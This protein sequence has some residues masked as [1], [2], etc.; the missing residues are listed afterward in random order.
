MSDQGLL[1]YVEQ[2]ILDRPGLNNY[3]LPRFILAGIEYTRKNFESAFH[4]YNDC[5][6]IANHKRAQ[7]PRLLCVKHLIESGYFDKPGPI[8]A[9]K[10]DVNVV[11]AALDSTNTYYDEISSLSDL[12]GSHG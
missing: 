9:F 5:L 4:L 10:H 11:L 8:T 6:A 1:N 7:I 2:F 3:F 12:L